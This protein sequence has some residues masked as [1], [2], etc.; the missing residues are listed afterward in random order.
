MDGHARRAAHDD[1]QISLAS[2]LAGVESRLPEP[3]DKSRTRTLPVSAQMR[4]DAN[5]IQEFV[6]DGRDLAIRGV[7]ENGITTARFDVQGVTGELR[8]AE[9][10]GRTAIEVRETRAQACARGA[11]RG[12]RAVADAV[13]NCR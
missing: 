10:C 2:N 1:W 4:V 3:F 12:R 5:G 7:V 6:V 13:A 8:R 11:R 9:Q